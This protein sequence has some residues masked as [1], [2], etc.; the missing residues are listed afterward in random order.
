[1]FV[2]RLILREWSLFTAEGAVQ[3]GGAK[4]SV[5]AYVEGGKSKNPDAPPQLNFDAIL[6]HSTVNYSRKS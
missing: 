1:M 3:M 2:Q 6:C 4:I 5:Q